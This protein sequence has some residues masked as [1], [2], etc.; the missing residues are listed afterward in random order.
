MKNKDYGGYPEDIASLLREKNI[1]IED[2]VRIE[3]EGRVY[4]G[5]LLPR[6]AL[7][8]LGDPYC[9]I[10]KLDSGYNIGVKYDESMKI[11]RVGKKIELESFPKR[12]IEKR[13][14]LPQITLLH[15]GGTIAS[16]IDYLTGGVSVEFTPEE[17]FYTVPELFDIVGFRDV[18]LLFNVFSEDMFL[19]QWKEMAKETAKQLNSGADGVVISHGTDTMH[20]SSAILSFMLQNLGKPVVLTGAQRSSDRGSFD[21]AINLI[22]SSYVAGHSDIAEVSVVM[23]GETSDTFCLINRGTKVRKMHTS[24]RDAFRPINDLPIG[25]IWPDG[26]LEII[27]KNYRKRD[28]DREVIPDTKYEEKVALIKAYPG[29]FPGIVDF[30]VDK[31]FKGLVIEGTGL[32]HVPTSTPEKERSWLENIKRAIE[33]DLK[34]VMTSQCLYGRVHPL[35]YRNLRLLSSAGVIYVEDMLPEVA[36]VKLS[37]VLGH[38][39]DREEVR[40]LMLKNIA[41]EISETS[42]FRSFLY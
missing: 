6:P 13:K 3:K 16:R 8:D 29:S 1:K 15:T 34:I 39:E 28:K 42:D 12:K 11:D 2:R 41:G 24:R 26:S 25:K 14:D 23:H 20:Y 37:W 36:Y 17:L 10:I 4:E 27:N 18:K 30:Y 9:L 32:G 33:E 19:T 5:Y 21:G 31:K 7:V 38:T 40:N 35:V 22:C